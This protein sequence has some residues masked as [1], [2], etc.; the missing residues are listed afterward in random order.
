MKK[1][2]LALFLSFFI[3][4]SASAQMGM[5]NYYP[6]KNIDTK[7]QL[8]QSSTIDTFLQDIY[9]TQKTKDQSKISCA[10]VT[11]DQFEKLGDAVMGYGTTEQEHTSMEN[12]MGG[13]GSATLKQSHINMGRSYLG[14]WSNYNSSPVTMMKYPLNNTESSSYAQY[15]NSYPNYLNMMG[16]GNYLG[17]G[18]MGSYNGWGGVLTMVLVWILL[19]LGIVFIIKKLKK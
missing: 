5:M 8:D 19:I 12:M 7:T 14:C 11:D 2:I 3:T 16:R 13:E 6:Q 18:M 10:K 9:T 4:S 17:Y 1:I 15:P